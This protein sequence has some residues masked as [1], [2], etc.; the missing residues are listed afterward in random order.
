MNIDNNIPQTNSIFQQS[1]WLEAVAPGKWGEIIVFGDKKI[2]ARMP[3]VIK[4]KF[5]LTAITMPPLTQTL[6]PWMQ[7]TSQRYERQ[8]SEQKELMS[9]LIARLPRHDYF[10]QCFSPLITNWQPFY[11]AGF[12]QTTKYTYRIP[13]LSN[14]DVIWSNF[15]TNVRNHIRKAQAKINIRNDLG[16]KK[17]FEINRMS[18]IRQNIEPPYGY[19]L[20]ERLEKACEMHKAIRLFF[21]QDDQNNIHAVSCLVWDSETAYLI[22]NGQ[23]PN[24]KGSGAQHLLIW[25]AIQ[26]ASTVSKV[27]DFEGSMIEPIEKYNRRFGSMQ[28]P[29]FHI[30]KMGRRMKFVKYSMELMRAIFRE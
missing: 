1:W 22:M 7:I 10:S 28:T 19:D 2:R 15:S 5:G 6:G 3:Y 24:H 21:A 8:L 16:I 18:F 17:F 4:K 9:E 26:Y 25:E 30:T 29:Y 13:D 23:D 12:Q 14:L 11:W 20:L 27:F